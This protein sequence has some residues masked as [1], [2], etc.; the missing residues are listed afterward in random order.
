MGSMQGD[1]TA[2]RSARTAW[3]LIGSAALCAALIST[4]G[5]RFIPGR[6][7]DALSAE[8]AMVLED[9]VIEFHLRYRK[10]I[11]EAGEEIQSRTSDP[12]RQLRALY[13]QLLSTP[14]ARDAAFRSDPLTA[15]LD[16]WSLV[17]QT[18]DHFETG[19]GRE[20]FGEDSEVMLAAAHELEKEIERI[21]E[22]TLSPEALVRA[23]E[24]VN[25]FSAKF[26]AQ[27]PFSRDT[28]RTYLDANQGGVGFSWLLD[29]SLSPLRAI[30][31][32]D[33]TAVALHEIAK[34]TDEMTSMVGELPDRIRLQSRILL[35][36][37]GQDPNISTTVASLDRLARTGESLGA[38]AEALPERV[39]AQVS[40]AIRELEEA[41]PELRATVTELRGTLDSL[42]KS[43]EA[44]TRASDGIGTMSE[45]L[46]GALVEFRGLMGDFRGEPAATGT[47]SVGTPTV[48]VPS[49][50]MPP[51]GAEGATGESESAPDPT[52][53][54]F[55]IEE[56]TRA[57]EA[58]AGAAAELRS[59]IV[60]LRT[61]A[62]TE[63][64]KAAIDRA[65]ATAKGLA[66][67][68]TLYVV[69]AF[70][71]C[72]AVVLALRL[73]SRRFAESARGAAGGKGAP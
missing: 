5:C 45:R 17:I 63:E 73:L 10:A 33:Q 7:D 49:P 69:L 21:A 64:S 16:L 59:A 19:A 44:A 27:N 9:R 54:P 57:A 30:G 46:E 28:I 6:N 60:E 62:T 72:A 55:D 47:G 4:A 58:I 48:P 56:Y 66:G 13:F 32:L 67:R 42:E 34:S 53:K 52:G 23:R 26:P 20:V 65:A 43:L 2:G 51:P 8:K 50:A 31:G 3:V 35:H 12:K 37:V 39:G 25:A 71:G 41:S 24:T 40:A 22:L 68:V 1:L 14:Y 18:R 15:L 11:A 36:E 70:A 29:T 61:L 38:T